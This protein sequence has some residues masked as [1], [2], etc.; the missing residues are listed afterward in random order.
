MKPEPGPR[1]EREA[2][3]LLHR[4]HLAALLVALLAGVPLLAPAGALPNGPLLGG[5]V[6]PPNAIPL[7]ALVPAG[8]PSVAGSWEAPFEGQIP[9]VHMALL[10]DQRVIYWSGDQAG[11]ADWIYFLSTVQGSDT[12][13]LAPPYT[14]D[15]VATTADPD[16]ATSN[17]FC[18]GHTILPDG[19]L[20]S[21]GGSAWHATLLQPGQSFVDG[22]PDARVFDWRTNEWTN[23]TPMEVARWYPTVMTTSQ[24]GLAAS[25]ISK[26]IDP[27]TMQ[28]NMERFDGSS[29]SFVP[30]GND[31]LP[32][33]PRLFEVPSGPLKGDIYY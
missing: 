17:L 19:R 10:P 22:V 32:L 21:A 23:V 13:L 9:A 15:T 26:L 28:N 24:G 3:A 30:G 5:P 16:N 12:R 33:Y 2:I 25:G 11:D 20:L 1:R 18:S 4:V 29:W 14:A 7:P 31:S 8:P 6:G 27:T